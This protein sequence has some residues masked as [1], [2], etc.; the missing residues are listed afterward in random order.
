MRGDLPEVAPAIFD[1]AAIAVRQIERLFDHQ[2]PSAARLCLGPRMLYW[3]AAW[4]IA[5]DAR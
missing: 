5:T 3:A 1:H 2:R 4:R